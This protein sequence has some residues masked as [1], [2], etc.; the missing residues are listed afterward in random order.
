VERIEG[1]VTAVEARRRRVS[2]NVTGSERTVE[3]DRLV[4]AA[5][6]R[7][8]EP[9]IPGLR[10]FSFNVDNY[11]AGMRLSEHIAALPMA[12]ASLGQY[13]VLVLG[14]G[15]TGIETACEMPARLRE[16][17]AG[18]GAGSAPLRTILADQAQ[19]IGSDMG[20]SARPVIER[21][22]DSLG[23]ERLTGVALKSVDAHG[24]TLEGGQRIE[25]DTVVW[26]A[27][28][29]ASPLTEQFGVE[30]DRFGRLPVDEY[31]RVIRISDVFAAGGC[32]G[33]PDRRRPHQCDV[34]SAR[35][36]DGP[37]CR[38][39]RGPRFG[40]RADAPAAQ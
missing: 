9:D 34:V 25:A 21:A 4:L 29:R 19:R 16:A 22:L 33:A 31:L 3:Y 32:S 24:V 10:E 8:Y 40:Q 2:A 14:A 11:D 13:T 39:Q 35:A 15:L 6:S 23:I 30:R 37:L 7:L 17:V 26:T 1:E 27:G 5:G 28:M 20:D 38:L 36:A 12:P 18:V